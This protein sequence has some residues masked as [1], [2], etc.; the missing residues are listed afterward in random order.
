MRS[1]FQIIIF[2]ILLLVLLYVT[3]SY[4]QYVLHLPER[5]KEWKR[6]STEAD[7]TVDVNTSSV[8]LES[9]GRIRATFRF[10]LAKQETAF[11]KPDAKYKTRVE[12]IQFDVREDTYRILETKLLDSRGKAVYESELDLDRPWKKINSVTAGQFFSVAVGLSPLG[13]WSV[14]AARYPY[15]SPS[16]TDEDS[17]LT[18]LRPKTLVSTRIT[19]FEVGKKSCSSPTY[20]PSMMRADE[21]VK[22]TGVSLKD[23]GFSTDKVEAIKIKCETPQL[24]SEVHVLLLAS[25]TRATLLSGGVLLDLEKLQY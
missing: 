21:F 11:E 25:A 19:K 6:I 4:S 3:P 13:A 7:A 15:G 10:S 9:N 20:E 1:L 24:V 17:L 16:P 18:T 5:S 22:W 12:T 14:V 8:V 23:A 2:P